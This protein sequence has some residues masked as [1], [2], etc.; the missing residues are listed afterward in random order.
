MVLLLDAS[1]HES[2]ASGASASYARC[3]AV[4]KQIKSLS[5]D[6]HV[7]SSATQFLRASLTTCGLSS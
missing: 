4:I 5:G 3:A 1:V 2:D 7:Q 6:Y